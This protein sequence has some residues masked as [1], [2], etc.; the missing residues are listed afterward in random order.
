MYHYLVVKFTLGRV[1][2]TKNQ[3]SKPD[4][5]FIVSPHTRVQYLRRLYIFFLYFDIYEYSVLKC[6]NPKSTLLFLQFYS[7]TIIE[8][9]YAALLNYFFF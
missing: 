1:R 7:F 3:L 2:L 5:I 6:V 9:Y 4:L 8:F